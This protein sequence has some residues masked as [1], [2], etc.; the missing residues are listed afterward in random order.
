MELHGDRVVLRSL[1]EAQVARLAE[2]GGEPEVARW[3][4]GIDEAYLRE[5]LVAGL[6]FA[7]LSEGELA[8]LIQ[9]YEELEPEFRHAGMDL[10]L[11]SAFQDRGLGTDTVRTMARYLIRERGHHRLTIDPAAHNDRAIRCYEN[12]GFRRVGIMREYWL[13][14]DGVQR[15]GLLLDLLASELA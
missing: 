4:A 10:F 14:P 13:D 6:S 7:I 1:A 3:W 5:E 8:G 2:I 11:G 15:D 9:F 12:V